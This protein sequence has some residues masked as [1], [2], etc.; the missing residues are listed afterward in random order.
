MHKTMRTILCAHFSRVL[1]CTT[2][3]GAAYVLVMEFSKQ[4]SG[5]EIALMD[6][7]QSL[8]SVL[9]SNL[10]YKSRS[11]VSVSQNYKLVSKHHKS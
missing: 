6:L 10:N 5:L 8:I 3:S 2:F 9:V 4:V 11:R 1:M 7:F